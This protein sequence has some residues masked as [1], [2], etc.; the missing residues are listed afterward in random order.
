MANSHLIA[1][2]GQ[3]RADTS[4]HFPDPI[5]GNVS[6]EHTDHRASTAPLTLLGFGQSLR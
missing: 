2:L 3:R 6:A 5:S 4:Q 1:P